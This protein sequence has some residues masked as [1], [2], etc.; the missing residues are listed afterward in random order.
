MTKVSEKSTG[1]TAS[2]PRF[3]ARK[4]PRSFGCILAAFGGIAALLTIIATTQDES[5][6]LIIASSLMALALI[7]MFV[8]GVCAIIAAYETVEVSTQGLTLRLGRIRMF[9]IP[10]DKIRSVVATTKEYRQGMSDDRQV[11]MLQ[12]YWNG[13]H[14]QNMAIWFQWSSETADAFRELLPNVDYLL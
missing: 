7:A 4:L 8:V 10:A 2:F 1:T 9:H 11:Y 5:I 3:Y 14:P 6:L 12:L 13:K